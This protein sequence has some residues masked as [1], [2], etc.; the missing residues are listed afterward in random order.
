MSLAEKSLDKIFKL[1]GTFK[2]LKA[3]FDL[4]AM[5][6][7]GAFLGAGNPK[8]FAKATVDMHKFVVSNKRYKTW[9]ATIE[10]SSDY[11]YMMEDGLS[12][13]DTSGDVLRSEERFVGNLISNIHLFTTQLNDLLW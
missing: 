2:G 8:E 9:M 4:S 13:T 5:L 11:V 6:R 3:T 7:Q 1:F 12:I 10:S